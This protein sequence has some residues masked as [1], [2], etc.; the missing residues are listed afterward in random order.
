M[1]PCAYDLGRVDDDEAVEVVF[2]WPKGPAEPAV[3]KG[4]RRAV[5]KNKCLSHRLSGDAPWPLPTFKC[6]KFLTLGQSLTWTAVVTRV[7]GP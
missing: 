4:I 7:T 6:G 2:G 1:L 5:R 3:L